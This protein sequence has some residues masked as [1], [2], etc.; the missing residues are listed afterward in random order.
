M[1]VNE[2]QQMK[3]D[4]ELARRLQEEEYGMDIE[5]RRIRVEKMAERVLESDLNEVFPEE[6]PAIKITNPN[7]NVAED[8]LDT[9]FQDEDF[10]DG[11]PLPSPEAK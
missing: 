8:M 6:L 10:G 7:S 11:S 5:N 1:S 3:E 2:N 9:Q 4:E